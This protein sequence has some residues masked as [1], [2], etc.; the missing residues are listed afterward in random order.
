MKAIV[1]DK[2]KFFKNF[3]YLTVFCIRRASISKQ[4]MFDESISTNAYAIFVWT[5]KESISMLCSNTI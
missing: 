3:N 2:K 1:M 4:E 5:V